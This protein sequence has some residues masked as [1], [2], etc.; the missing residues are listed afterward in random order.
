VQRVRPQFSVCEQ[1]V[2]AVANVHPGMVNIDSLHL[3]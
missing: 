2:E 1:N 3:L